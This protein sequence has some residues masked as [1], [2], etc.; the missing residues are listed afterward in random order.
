LLALALSLAGRSQRAEAAPREWGA[1]KYL[2]QAVTRVMASMRKVGDDFGFDEGVCIMGAFL[3]PKA[4]VAFDRPLRAGSAYVIL[5]GGDN[6][7]E[8]LDIEVLGPDG[9]VV[10]RDVETNAVPVVR[11]T[12]PRSGTYTIRQ[13]L[14]KARSS[15]FCLLAVLRQGGW[16]VPR[17]NLEAATTKL[18]SFGTAVDQTTPKAVTFHDGANNWA[19]FGSVLR[20]GD[21]YT[22]TDLSLGT[23]QRVMLAVG[24]ASA[25]D[26][27]LFILDSAGSLVGKDD[28]PDALPIVRLDTRATTYSMRVKNADSRGPTLVLAAI[29]KLGASPIVSLPALPRPGAGLPPSIPRPPVMPRPPSPVVGAPGAGPTPEAAKRA[30]GKIVGAIVAEAVAKGKM[31]KPK[32]FAE[33]LTQEALR[34]GAIRV[35]DELIESALKDA[36]PGR[37]LRQIQAARRVISLDLDGKLSVRNFNRLQAKEDLLA[38]LRKYDPGTAGAAEVADFIYDVMQA[39]RSRR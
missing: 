2:T 33:A 38:E 32:N 8:D 16:D 35:R 21:Q 3:A 15:S 37:P 11:F 5:G 1:G 39:H 7:A 26:L 13:K 28:K 12:A 10:A 27:D 31:R 29:L 22:H 24:D 18:V 25:R 20:K 30:L 23:G 36:F 19:V 9:R 17:S 4:T 6:D 14:Y 34:Q